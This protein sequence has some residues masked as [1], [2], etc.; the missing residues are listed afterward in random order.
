MDHNEQGKAGTSGDQAPVTKSS[1]PS[2]FLVFFV[3]LIVI[4][5]DLIGYHPLTKPP[6]DPSHVAYEA[7]GFLTALISVFVY[8]WLVRRPGPD[9]ARRQFALPKM[10]LWIASL[11]LMVAGVGLKSA[12]A[13]VLLLPFHIDPLT[14]MLVDGVIVLVKW[15]GLGLFAWCMTGL[16][17]LNYR[18]AETPALKRKRLVWLV[19]FILLFL[20][21]VFM[22]LG[23]D[24]S[25]LFG[26]A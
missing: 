16:L 22:N 6:V 18:T 13:L 10:N 26:P 9:Q 3:Y 8:A 15:A 4:Y 1:Q 11:A 23:Y 19:I 25:G 24:L 7:F 20:I 21:I 5:L 17:F 14:A 2:W 12:Y